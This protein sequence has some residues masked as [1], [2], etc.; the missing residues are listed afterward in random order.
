ML[1]ANAEIINNEW[2][3]I[4]LIHQKSKIKKY[5][6]NPYDP[7]RLCFFFALVCNSELRFLWPFCMGKD[8]FSNV[9]F[10]E[11]PYSFFIFSIISLRCSFLMFS[12]KYDK[13][14]G[15][16]RALRGVNRY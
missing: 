5:H 11:S 1:I 6:I 9:L 4:N 13:I 7:L 8:L 3:Y 2:K 15:S 12:G 16:I 14:Q 10:I